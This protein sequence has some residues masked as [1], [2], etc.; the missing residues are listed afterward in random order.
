MIIYT[1]IRPEIEDFVVLRLFNDFAD[2]EA[3]YQLHSTPL[4]LKPSPQTIRG[5]LRLKVK[6]EWTRMPW[7]N[8]TLRPKSGCLSSRS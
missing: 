3:V 5:I 8:A 2:D 7:K 6:G 1:E 4:D